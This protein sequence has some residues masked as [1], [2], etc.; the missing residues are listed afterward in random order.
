NVRE[1][2]NMVDR[3]RIHWPHGRGELA[4]AQMQAWLPELAS[5]PVAARAVADAAPDGPP[6]RAATRPGNDTLQQL[7][8]AHGGNREQVA[9]ALGVSRTTLWRWLRSTAG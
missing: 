2:R 9:Q 3:L 5:S 8:D 6:Q 4:L 7:L 1:L